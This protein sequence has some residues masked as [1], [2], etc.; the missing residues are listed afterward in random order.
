M[1]STLGIVASHVRPVIYS[2]VPDALDVGVGKTVTWSISA[3]N[4][5]SGTIYYT[6]SNQTNSAS[7]A[8]FTDVQVNGPIAITN[9]VG[10]LT[11]TFATT[12]ET[13]NN[14]AT[15]L[16]RTGSITGPIVAIASTV[17]RAV[18]LYST[19]ASYLSSWTVPATITRS[20]SYVVPTQSFYD[21][22]L[23]KLVT[24]GYTRGFNIRNA[25]G[26]SVF[27][28]ADG[29]PAAGFTAF[30]MLPGYYITWTIGGLS[31]PQTT[32]LT[33]YSQTNPEI[34]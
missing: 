16:L 20:F 8:D 4:F 12:S 7:T 13:I 31:N 25:A 24:T 33:I 27:V 29:I 10:T 17:T 28:R 6:L 2:I 15:V 23:Q 19:T 34:N 26:T 14:Y 32:G 18:P 9:D 5:G 22:R 3:S 30:K 21:G 11:K 1:P